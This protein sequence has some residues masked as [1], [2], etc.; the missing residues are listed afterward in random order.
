LEVEIPAVVRT[1]PS[2][3]AA[4]GVKVEIADRG[5]G[6]EGS[7]DL[8]DVAF[9]E[10]LANLG[11]RGGAETEGFGGSGRAPVVVF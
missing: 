2:V 3:T 7:F 5:R 1:G 6:E 4:Q 11:Q 9:S 8:E 10:E